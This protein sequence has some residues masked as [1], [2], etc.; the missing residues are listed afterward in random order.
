MTSQIIGYTA[1]QLVS[2]QPEAPPYAS[3]KLP[4]AQFSGA[5]RL[6]GS[7]SVPPPPDSLQAE[8]ASAAITLC[9]ACALYCT[10]G[11]AGGCMGAGPG[12]IGWW[13]HEKILVR[14]FR[15]SSKPTPSEKGTPL[16]QSQP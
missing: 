14:G 12:L 2:P 10:S 9:A 6:L 7:S 16:L 5:T 3:L 1:L 4:P 15:E 8:P 11:C 13:L